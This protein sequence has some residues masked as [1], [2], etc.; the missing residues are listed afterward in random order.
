MVVMTTHL[1]QRTLH[2]YNIHKDIILALCRTP[3]FSIAVQITVS[4]FFCD[5]FNAMI[6]QKDIFISEV[7]ASHY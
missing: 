2:N 7:L 6:A 5:F 3:I 4:A 1:P